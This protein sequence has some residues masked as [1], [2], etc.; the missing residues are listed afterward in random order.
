MMMC[1]SS[2]EHFQEALA[3]VMF[4]SLLSWSFKKRVCSLSGFKKGMI[5]GKG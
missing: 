2:R 3:S 1:R 4:V 5:V